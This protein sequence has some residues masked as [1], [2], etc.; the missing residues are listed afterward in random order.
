MHLNPLCWSEKRPKMGVLG[1]Q[2]GDF[3][4]RFLRKNSKLDGTSWSLVAEFAV[5]S[6]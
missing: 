1:P 2:N 4:K 3:G 6:T 5:A